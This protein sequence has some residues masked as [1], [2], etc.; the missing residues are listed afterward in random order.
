M[1]S[2]R[3]RLLLQLE[4]GRHCA[5][6]ST[7]FNFILEPWMF[8]DVSRCFHFALWMYMSVHDCTWLYMPL[9]LR[10][11]DLAGS[12]L[13][14]WK[15]GNPKFD[16]L[17]KFSLQKLHIFTSVPYLSHF[18]PYF[19]TFFD[20]PIPRRKKLALCFPLDAR[21]QLFVFGGSD[22]A[23]SYRELVITSLKSYKVSW[24]VGISYNSWLEQLWKNTGSL[25]LTVKKQIMTRLDGTLPGP[26]SSCGHVWPHGPHC[27]V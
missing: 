12:S 26:G 20:N 1:S 2:E 25:P 18:I 7:R 14:L 24:L 9:A 23:A 19:Y 10:K 15:Q 5:V 17:S 3:K 4:V 27:T 8:S 22:K 16:P 13:L 11:T 6:T 21:G